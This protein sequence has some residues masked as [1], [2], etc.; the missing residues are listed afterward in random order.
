[1]LRAREKKY[2]APSLFSGR[3]KEGKQAK[4]EEKIVLNSPHHF[5]GSLF[6]LRS[7]RASERAAS[8]PRLRADDKY[9]RRRYSHIKYI[10]Y[11]TLDNV[12]IELIADDDASIRVK[13]EG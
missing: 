9:L 10:N 13:L 2:C 11:S 6:S 5:G 8:A 1:M 3:E 7:E 12:S 4:D